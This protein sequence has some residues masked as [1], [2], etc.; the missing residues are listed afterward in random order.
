MSSEIK[1]WFL[2]KDQQQSGPFHFSTIA[3]QVQSGEIAE[4][5]FLYKSGWKDWRPLKECRSELALESSPPPP[6]PTAI[7]VN[8]AKMVEIATHDT[9][10][11]PRVTMEGQIIVH[12]NN[13]LA[14]GSGVDISATGLFVSTNKLLFKV[15]DRLKVTCKITGGQIKPFQ[16]QAE[17]IRYNSEPPLGYGL[18]FVELDEKISNQIR[19]LIHQANEIL[20]KSSN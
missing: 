1:N 3:K 7:A 14:I 5:D 8:P 18:R 10:R 9:E 2:F 15:G 16:A 13:D 19:S 4:S 17:V 6:P 11:S 12:N 20:N